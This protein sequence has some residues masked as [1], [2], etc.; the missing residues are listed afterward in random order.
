MK[1]S[2]NKTSKNSASLRGVNL[3]QLQAI[4]KTKK[5]KS[6][7]IKQL[8]NG[9]WLKSGQ[10]FS[11]FA[12]LLLV[13]LVG[14]LSSIGV[15]FE[16]ILTGLS[17]T[18]TTIMITL[19]MVFFNY[20]NSELLD[21][22]E[23]NVLLPMPISGDTILAS[24][25][26]H[27]AKFMSLI[28]LVCSLPSIV[29]IAYKHSIMISMLFMIGVFLLLMLLLALGISICLLA[30]INTEPRKIKSA[31]SIILLSLVA[32]IVIV[33]NTFMVTQFSNID[34]A[35]SNISGEWMYLYP[36]SWMAAIAS[37][38]FGQEEVLSKNLSFLAFFVPIASM[39]LSFVY[40]GPR[41][42]KFLFI[43]DGPDS[44]QDEKASFLS[45]LNSKIFYKCFSSAEFAYYKMFCRLMQTEYKFRVSVSVMCGMLLAYCGVFF[46]DNYSKS[47]QTLADSRHYF[48][49]IYLVS[50][51]MVTT[52]S[53][54]KYSEQY[55]AAW[56]YSVLPIHKPGEVIKSLAIAFYIKYL[57]PM[58][59]IVVLGCYYVWGI[60]T[61]S[62][63]I[64]VCLVSMILSLLQS[65]RLRD[66]FPFSEFDN[67]KSSS[68]ENLLDQFLITIPLVFAASIHWLSKS[69][70]GYVGTITVSFLS[71]VAIYVL[72]RVF[73]NLEWEKNNSYLSAS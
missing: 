60:G 63:T 41:F 4:L 37:Y 28:A 45:R 46:I 16:S 56:V 70:F 47:L 12:L 33:S 40:L 34:F 19:A 48:M 57:L 53:R 20:F 35:S 42:K 44:H 49:F 52:M 23:N 65:Y 69:T 26:I 9:G 73:N 1:V 31:I 8:L 10:H 3:E 14:L 27:I 11:G 17:Y 62:D 51:F 66:V 18:Y 36:P 39:L 7:S 64:L 55:K 29:F 59:L 50:C 13:L 21:V 68:I 15:L 24:R 6:L 22:T 32:L 72:L 54:V 61:L 5:F 25:Y 38:Y 43:L 71:L 30:L 58:N 2:S 67:K